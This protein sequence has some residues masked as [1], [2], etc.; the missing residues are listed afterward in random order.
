MQEPGGR[1]RLSRP[2]RQVFGALL[3]GV[4]LALALAAAGHASSPAASLHVHPP[5]HERESLNVRRPHT[6]AI[7]VTG[8]ATRGDLLY[9]FQE[10]ASGCAQLQGELELAKDAQ[11]LYYRFA[12]RG[13]FDKK[14]V[15]D[16]FR[17]AGRHWACA[18]LASG[19]DRVL[20]HRFVP[21][22][23]SAP[24]IGRLELDLP[25]RA[26]TGRHYDLT[27]EGFAARTD[28]LWIYVEPHRAGRC[29]T[30][31][32]FHDSTYR[33]HHL[34]YFTFAVAGKF[35]KVS[36]W[37][38]SRPGRYRACAYLIETRAYP[39]RIL[40]RTASYRVS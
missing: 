33:A 18:Y 29:S 19:S 34:P 17:D 16:A 10:S 7:T 13:E 6:F 1:D 36:D 5:R 31:Y 26:G 21:F 3:A 22:T 14:T 4:G 8:S 35:R 32:A 39:Q 2:A 24:A 28:S 38:A 11:E 25:R 30:W 37:S 40:R 9:V 15:W 27:L 12:V 20:Q 23:V